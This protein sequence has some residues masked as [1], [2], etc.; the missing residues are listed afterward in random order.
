MPSSSHNWLA[1]STAAKLSIPRFDPSMAQDS[2]SGPSVTVPTYLP[3]L[4]RLILPQLMAQ[5]KHAVSPIL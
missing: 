1:C 3:C 4:T 2:Y 5:A